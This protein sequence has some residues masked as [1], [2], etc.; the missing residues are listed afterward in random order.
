LLP[1]SKSWQKSLQIREKHVTIKEQLVGK[2]KNI[3]GFGLSV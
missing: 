3:C 2:L 1:W